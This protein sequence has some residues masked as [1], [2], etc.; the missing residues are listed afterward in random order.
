MIELQRYKKLLND[1]F[2]LMTIGDGKKPNYK[3]KPLQE[4]ALTAKEFEN[5]YNNPTTKGVGIL[6]GYGHLE[7]IDVDLKVF[8]T[9]KEKKDFW[10]IFLS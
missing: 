8:S 5:R 1:G 6:T 7:C 3:W 9:A 4:K 10:D 2:S